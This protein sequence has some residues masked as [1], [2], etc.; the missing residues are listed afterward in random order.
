MHV[1]SIDTIRRIRIVILFI[2]LQSSKFIYIFSKINIYLYGY[3]Q[4][5]EYRWK[6]FFDNSS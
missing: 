2:L 1:K 5:T 4:L 3:T 6:K